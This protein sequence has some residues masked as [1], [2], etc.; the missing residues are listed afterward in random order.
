[1]LMRR[2]HASAGEGGKG[3]ERAGAAL[4]GPAQVGTGREERLA[5]RP[6]RGEG[7]GGG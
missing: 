6:A 4:A 2:A 7:A 1:M 5:P 3:E